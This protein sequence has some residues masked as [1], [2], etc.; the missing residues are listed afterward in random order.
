MKPY[1]LHREQLHPDCSPCERTWI[2]CDRATG[3][4]LGTTFRSEDGSSWL[5]QV[6]GRAGLL[7][8][9]TR[10][11]AAARVWAVSRAISRGL[12]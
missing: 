7:A 1:L 9:R 3:Q 12:R 5:L 10:A 11:E 4:R 2:I 8:R 6:E